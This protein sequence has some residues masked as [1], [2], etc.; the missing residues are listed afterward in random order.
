[1]SIDQRPLIV[2]AGPVG[3]AAA[4]F[5]R[6]QGLAPRVVETRPEP[7]AQSKALAVNPR[8]L[9]LL[10]STGVAAQMLEL[11]RPVRGMQFH[12]H[13]RV[14][15]ELT[16][17]GI[18][19][20]YP[21]MLG[22][23]QAT[24]E[25]LLAQAFIAAGGEIERQ[26]EL[27]SCHNVTSGVAAELAHN[28]TGSSE[29][30]EAPWLLAADG[31][32]SIVRKQLSVPFNGTTFP[33]TWYL[34]DVPLKTV[35]SPEFG[36]IIFC[37]NGGFLFL[38]PVF[39]DEQLQSSG[40]LVWRVLGNRPDPVA[41]LEE[42]QAIG[43]PVWESSFHVSHRINGELS[44]GNAYFAGDAAHIHSPM[45]ARGMNLGIEDA[46]V[47]ANLVRTGRL[48]EYHSLRYPV[49]R[50]V[51]HEV[52]FFT[53]LISSNALPFRF[54]RRFVLPFV[55]RT[56]ASIHIKRTVTGLDHELPAE[57]DP[58]DDAPAAGRSRQQPLA[59]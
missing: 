53:R 30:I 15:T 4:L 13:G 3:L 41:Q 48:T 40:S 56:P 6:R 43:P 34:A 10:E 28:A 25:R 52:E 33:E 7:A 39:G 1:M 14:T 54:A 38:L 51:V 20:K 27:T 11:G 32:R 8:V 37:R 55:A 50:K 44:V 16:L 23:S 29:S 5:L 59:V 57:L 9:D 12:R 2:G 49:D 35:L 26:V 58:P 31:A 18:H 46:W 17:A 22:L 42:A 45:G 36:H 47:F 24:T 19:P 21:F